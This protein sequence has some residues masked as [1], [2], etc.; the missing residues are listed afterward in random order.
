MNLTSLFGMDTTFEGIILYLPLCIRISSWV[1]LGLVFM[2]F[3]FI[4]IS[5]KLYKNAPDDLFVF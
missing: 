3:I 2:D 1:Q 4:F 5:W